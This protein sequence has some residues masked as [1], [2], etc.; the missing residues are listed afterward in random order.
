MDEENI[1]SQIASQVEDALDNK[2]FESEVKLE[3]ERL[4]LEEKRIEA[5]ISIAQRMAERD[6]NV[7]SI[8]TGIDEYRSMF[9]NFLNRLSAL[10]PQ[11]SENHIVHVES[12]TEIP[13]DNSDDEDDSDDNENENENE[14]LGVAS[15]DSPSDELVEELGNTADDVTDEVGNAVEKSEEN[16]EENINGKTPR[17]NRKKRRRK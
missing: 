16:I 13:T 1:P 10:L 3:K 6:E 9:D 7:A 8:T 2:K 17:H 14:N 4:K 15:E 12:P 11:Q 5:D